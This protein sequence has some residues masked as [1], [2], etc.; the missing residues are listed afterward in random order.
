MY[1]YISTHI[2]VYITIMS[3]N[4]LQISN[5]VH[6]IHFLECSIKV[7]HF[8]ESSFIQY[9]YLKLLVEPIGGL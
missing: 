6:M 3:A 7:A 8:I 9:R 2:R 4:Y 1:T 5:K